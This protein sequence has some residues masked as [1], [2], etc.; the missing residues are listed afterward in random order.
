MSGRKLVSCVSLG[1]GME[2]AKL[3]QAWTYRRNQ[4]TGVAKSYLIFKT[5]WNGF[6]IFESERINYPGRIITQIKLVI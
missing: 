3:N 2:C 4:E 5:A 6:S 1:L